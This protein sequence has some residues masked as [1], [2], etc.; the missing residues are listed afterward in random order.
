MSAAL[1]VLALLAGAPQRPRPPDDAKVAERAR[2]A[3]G[4]FK[5]E[6]KGAL[7][8][9]MQTSP[10]VAIEVC[11]KQA[12]AM[13]TAHS[14]DGVTVGRAA[15]KL[16]NEANAPAPWLAPVLEALS[17]EKSGTDAFRVVTLP[18]GKLGYA[19]AIWTQPLCVSCHGET[20]AP[21]IEA[22]LAATYPKDAA[23]GFKEGDFRG[24][25]WAVLDAP[26]PAPAKKKAKR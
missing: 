22:K 7:T 2:A 3:L 21:G 11:S 25:F 19:E 4:P 16:R 12:P 18:D 8:T 6:L 26:P 15:A 17:K 9:A 13:A 24:V 5:K 23:R 14:K 1:V 10:E 20:L